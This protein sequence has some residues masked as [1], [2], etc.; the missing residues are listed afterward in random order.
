MSLIIVSNNKLIYEK[1]NNVKFINGEYID[2]LNEVRN[3]IHMGY[4]LVNH[5]LPA[6]IRM[7]FSPVRSILLD[8]KEKFDEYSNFV[9]ENSIEKYKLTMENRKIDYEN[10]KDYELVDQMLMESALE[11]YKSLSRLDIKI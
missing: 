2:V 4:V 1:N 6:S 8:K 7:V 3:L 9:I 5:P 10:K 11:E